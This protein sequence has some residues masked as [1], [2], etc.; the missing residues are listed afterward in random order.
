M[1]TFFFS[2]IPLSFSFVSLSVKALSAHIVSIEQDNIFF[3]LKE[4]GYVYV[5]S[6]GEDK[7]EPFVIS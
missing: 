5:Q 7:C 4:F 6:R 1:C 2:V 3:C